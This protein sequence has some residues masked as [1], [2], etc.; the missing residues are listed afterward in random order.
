MVVGFASGLCT[1]SFVATT[2]NDLEIVNHKLTSKIKI[3]NNLTMSFFLN[4]SIL[5]KNKPETRVQTTF[6]QV[7][8]CTYGS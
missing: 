2:L 6:L 3:I 8:T 7:I 1:F 5:T 4:I